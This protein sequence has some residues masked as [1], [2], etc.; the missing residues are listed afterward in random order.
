[1]KERSFE[2]GQGRTWSYSVANDPKH[3][4]QSLDRPATTVRRDW[5]RWPQ[6][7]HLLDEV[8]SRYRR[9]TVEE[10]A[11]IQGFD[12]SWV[13]VPSVSERDKISCLGNAVPPPL[14]VAIG[15]TLREHWAF[16]N[17]NSI[18]IC[19]GIGG[20][21][22]A[23]SA[24]GLQPAALIEFWEPA[25]SI[26]RHGKPW[27]PSKVFCCDVRDFNYAQ[28]KSV[29]M[30]LGGPPC[31]PWSQGGQRLGQADP[32]DL[33]GYVPEILRD[34]EPEVFLIEN[35]P[36]L[37][38]S[39]AHRGYLEKLTNAL[40]RPTETLSYGVGLAIFTAADYGVPQVRRR[41]FIL[42]FKDRSAA[43]AEKV[44]KSIGSAATHSEASKPVPGR[45]P[46]ISLG[47]AF[48]GLN[49]HGGWKP[50]PK[51][52]PC[53]ATLPPPRP[54][55]QQDHG[56][57]A[58]QWPGKGN[59]PR[60]Q[61]NLWQL[62]APDEAILYRPLLRCDQDGAPSINNSAAVVIHGDLLD[63]LEA[64]RPAA[65]GRVDL[66]Y[67]E[68]HRADFLEKECL[69]PNY[70][71]SVWLSILRECSARARHTL[72]QHGFYA[73][74]V[75]DSSYHYARLCL[76]EE[77]GA[78][79]YVCTIVW[80]KKYGP[81]NDLN[82]PTAA[83]EYIIVYSVTPAEDLPVMG[84]QITDDL[85]DDGDPRGPWVA[86]H[87]GAKSGSEES[88]FEVNAPP[89]RWEVISGELPPGA[90]RLNPLSGV[91]WGGGAEVEGSF[92]FRVRVTDSAKTTAEQ[93]IT[94]HVSA[95]AGD[96]FPNAVPWLFAHEDGVRVG[97]PL[98]VVSA[99]EW[100]IRLGQ[101]FSLAL[102]AA[103][104]KPFTFGE[105]KKGKP[106]QGRY[107]EF[108]RTTLSAAVLRD[109]VSF[110]ASGTALPS[111]KKHHLHTGRVGRIITWWDYERFGKSEDAT[112]HLNELRGKGLIPTAA[113]VA[114]PERLMQKLLELLAPETTARV[115][116]IGDNAASMASVCVKTGRQPIV[117]TSAAP[118][119]TKIWSECGFPRLQ[120]V[121]AGNDA[122]G[123]SS[124]VP[125]E[126]KTQGEILELE[127][128][129]PV[130]SEDKRDKF[131]ALNLDDYPSDQERLLE[132]V[133]SLAGF[134]MDPVNTQRGFSFD[135]ACCN[136]LSP[137]D[138]LNGNDL[139]IF[140][141][142]AH[143][144]PQTVLYES[145]SL[146]DQQLAS[147]PLR[148]LRY[149]EDLVGRRK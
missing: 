108:S 4:P 122:G 87:K 20:L 45:D 39:R 9:L 115:L 55:L 132:A 47:E 69:Y 54:A 145:T 134:F 110:G 82:V 76:D 143:T 117:L 1:M 97:G 44:L 113:L 30:L 112:R 59:L 64:L 107:W 3:R 79:N 70:R 100:T 78:G 68:A 6:E 18:E 119:S 138:P 147:S 89:Y 53:M 98:R 21:A 43:F 125:E 126:N 131:L 77:F 135:G 46:W 86:G 80:Q 65:R 106:G 84:F 8:R 88:K 95:Q 41:L 92:S 104:G 130:F 26:L 128:G 74:Q 33:L 83:Q 140:E 71:H 16:S 75:D 58:L 50:L 133:C 7:A 103:G 5:S 141:A 93:N 48:A 17:S 2:L 40:G 15:R 19:A 29:G 129:E 28:H 57:L 25:C 144:L 37:Y 63:A 105:K 61:H 111:T 114:K 36:G 56:Q 148:F 23:S 38:T 121:L 72:K 120:A 14:A 73:L 10:I 90:W 127:V 49:D 136:I 116:C 101:E 94:V 60:V 35:V 52:E 139:D 146:D 149:P 32:R 102:H 12:A 96:N 62:V 81:Q 85:T 123:I 66:V 109:D 31:Q 124:Q 27:Q 142:H 67:H 137:G 42:G 24:A 11:L 22:F 34:L 13:D 91:I 51:K 99:K 118:S